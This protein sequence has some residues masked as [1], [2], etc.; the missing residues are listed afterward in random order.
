MVGREAHRCVGDDVHLLARGAG[1]N[2]SRAPFGERADRLHIRLKIDAAKN[3]ASIGGF[4]LKT[5]HAMCAVAIVL[6]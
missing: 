6:L 3:A 1:P 4:D 5:C 2:V